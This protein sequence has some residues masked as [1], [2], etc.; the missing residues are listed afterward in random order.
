M[1]AN[2]SVVLLLLSVILLS[3]ITLEVTKIRKRLEEQ[4]K[5]SSS[6][7]RTPSGR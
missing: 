5:G 7:E 6:P 1:I 3:M 2:A 4:S